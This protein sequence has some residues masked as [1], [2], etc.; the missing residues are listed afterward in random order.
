MSTG[1]ADLFGAS[2]RETRERAEMEG[3]VWSDALDLKVMN[4]EYT[5]G[6]GQTTVHVFGRDRD[7]EWRHVEVVGHL[8]SFYIREDEYSPRVDN[9]YAVVETETHGADGERYVSLHGEPLVRV[10]THTPEQVGNLRELFEETW[11]ADV[12]YTTRFLID[13]GVKVGMRVDT[14][15]AIEEEPWLRGEM[16]VDAEAVEPLSVEETPS[17]EPRQAVIDIEVASDAGFPDADRAEYPVST[18]VGY[19]TYEDEYVGWILES[20]EWENGTADDVWDAEANPSEVSVT[21]MEF[22]GAVTDSLDDLRVFGEESAMLA[23]FHGWIESLRPDIISHWFGNSFDVPYL[24]NRSRGLNTFGYQDWSPLGETFVSKYEPVVSGVSCVDMLEA[25][26]KTQRHNL[27][28]KALDDVAE[29]ELGRGKVDFDVEGDGPEHTEMWKRKP[30]EFMAYN[31]VDVALVNRLDEEKGLIDLLDNLRTV[32]GVS[33]TDPIGGNIDMMDT[34][35]LRKAKEYGY[36]LPTA[37]EPDVGYYH[38]SHVVTPEP[39]VHEHV[40]YPDYSSL[41]PNM[42]YQCNISPETLVGTYEDLEESEYTKEDCVWSYIDTQTPPSL[43]EEVEAKESR[44]ERVYFLKP[45]VK[46]GF[47][48]SVL[49]DIM[50]LA[51]EYTG[52]MYEAVKRVRNSSYGVLGD[53]DSYGTGFRLFDWRLAEATTL[54]GQKVLKA[55]SEKFLD[56][57]REHRDGDE[58]AYLVGGDTDSVMTAMPNADSP[59]TAVVVAENVAEETN[60]W[61]DGYA[62]EMFGLES[63]EDAR[64]VLEIES[65]ATR[66]FFKADDDGR[67]DEGVKKRYAQRIRWNDE[68]GWLS[69]DEVDTAIKGFEY[70]RSDVADVTAETQKR[71]FDLLLESDDLGTAEEE[72]K[73]Y[74]SN[75]ITGLL[76]G[77][78]DENRFG[79]P[80][81][82]GQ[83]LDQY[84]STDRTPQPQYRGAKYA[85]DFIYGEDA[86]GEGSDAKYYYVEEGETGDGRRSTYSATTPEDGRY[87]DAISVLDADDLPGGVKIDRPKMVQKTIIDPMAPIFRTLGWGTEWMH[88]VKEEHTPPE[89]YRES[90][91]T[92]LEDLL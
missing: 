35:F 21:E 66:L 79:I 69:E 20:D 58:D 70:V 65:Y 84:G 19:D 22:D 81:G 87:V 9:H 14:S 44:M 41:Y 11:E 47:I 88:A 10:Y 16:R 82:I 80:F 12:F 37:V 68:D 90:G 18:I 54:G 77:S 67:S 76:D 32:T 55:G 34:L 74:V 63:E 6:G 13:Q 71:V 78:M 33:Y 43:K 61:L 51:D 89:Y 92:G 8:P 86:I 1:V 23:D 53:S 28:S 42:M 45:S 60:E 25:Y 73:R 57:V 4:V 64:M 85:N 83:S 56:A 49:D 29:K 75:R 30:V 38:G 72:A 62:V 31:L 5:D 91:Q 15:D 59:E 52:G 50:G 36:A 7:R 27:K 39:G 40:V 48:R 46:E 2:D 17:V 24:I 26:K 3:G